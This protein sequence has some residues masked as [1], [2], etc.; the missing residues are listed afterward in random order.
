MPASS[1]I[2]QEVSAS[3]PA[4]DSATCARELRPTREQTDHDPP[5][6]GTD[7]NHHAV[8]EETTTN[9]STEQ[10]DLGPIEAGQQEDND[11]NPGDH[12]ATDHENVNAPRLWSRRQTNG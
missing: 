11:S 12:S 4:A 9:I 5:Y 8:N 1:I 2:N 10:G 6:F 3:G 7:P